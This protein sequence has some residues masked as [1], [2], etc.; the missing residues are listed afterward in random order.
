MVNKFSEF[1]NEAKKQK[2][3][4]K[5][6]KSSKK[7]VAPTPYPM[8]PFGFVRPYDSYSRP[9]IINNNIN[10]GSGDVNDNDTSGSNNTGGEAGGLESGGEA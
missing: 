9:V 3:K 7:S 10:T 1:L 8:Y 6:K 2:K 5:K 4:K